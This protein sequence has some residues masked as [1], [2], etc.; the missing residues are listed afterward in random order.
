MSWGRVHI[1]RG[2]LSHAYEPYDMPGAIILLDFQVYDDAGRPSK[3]NYE[4][5]GQVQA[6]HDGSGDKVVTLGAPSSTQLKDY[7]IDADPTPESLEYDEGYRAGWK[8][9]R[10][11]TAATL[12][13]GSPRWRDGVMDGWRARPKPAKPAKRNPL[14]KREIMQES[15]RVS[16]LRDRKWDWAWLLLPDR[17][18]AWAHLDGRLITFPTEKLARVAAFGRLD[19]IAVEKVGKLYARRGPAAWARG[20]A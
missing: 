2:L 3:L 13:G 16:R 15:M 11:P 17:E 5:P 1:R 12:E 20:R 9:S 6:L 10:A 8:R 7:R 19:R 14:G 4:G 18:G